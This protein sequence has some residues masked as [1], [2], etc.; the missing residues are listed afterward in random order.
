MD[1]ILHSFVKFFFL[2]QTVTSG[3]PGTLITTFALEAPNVPAEDQGRRQD[4][5]TSALGLK[6]TTR[7]MQYSFLESAN[8]DFL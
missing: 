7:K 8:A 3:C 5:C 2:N 4:L 1:L 6:R